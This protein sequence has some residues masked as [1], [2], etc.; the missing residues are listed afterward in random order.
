MGGIPKSRQ[1]AVAV[2][3]IRL[4][5]SM[6]GRSL[7]LARPSLADSRRARRV[8]SGSLDIDEEARSLLRVAAG[9]QP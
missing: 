1:S 6:P 9:R 4:F 3:T 7:R 8:A 5:H 2:H